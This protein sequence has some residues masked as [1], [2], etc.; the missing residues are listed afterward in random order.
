[1]P[2]LSCYSAAFIG[3]TLQ[4]GKLTLALDYSL[5]SRKLKGSNKIKAENLYLGEKVSGEPAIHAPV[6]LGL[7][8]LR[9]TSGV[10]NLDVGVSGNLDDPGFSISGIVIK[11][12]VNIIVKAAASPFKLLAALVGG[13]EDL[14]EIDFEAGHGE[15]TPDNQARLKQLSDALA[16]RPQLAVKITGS[17][18][19]KDDAATLRKLRVEELVAASRKISVADLQAEAGEKNWWTVEK[20]RD[21]LGGINDSLG[22]PAAPDRTAQLQAKTPALKGDVLEA[23][24]DRQMFEDVS[25]K[26]IISTDDLLA[27][28][29]RRA[30]AIMQDL[31]DVLKLDQKR[32]SVSK[33][34]PGNLTGRVIKLE[35]VPL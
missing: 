35:L 34:R 30:R 8:L 18:S 24:V 27:L 31:V 20:N 5:Q 17:A 4:S 33:A 9:D 12:L 2:G 21:A 14:G 22:L 7:A 23:E 1:M 15:L 26:Q 16:Q 32:V 6:A 13:H 10:I 29:D 28:A 11:A 19:D 3:N 25:G